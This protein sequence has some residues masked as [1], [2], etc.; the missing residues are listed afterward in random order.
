MIEEIAALRGTPVFDLYAALE[1]QAD[2]FPD[3][4]HPNAEGA[5]VMAEFIA[6]FLLGV[7]LVPDFNQDGVLNLID[8]ALLAQQWSRETTAFDIAPAPD[9]DAVVGYADLR[10]LGLDEEWE[11]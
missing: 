2:L 8:F 4:I 6:P 9:G 7:R 5:G 1:P 10:G 11:R 3:G